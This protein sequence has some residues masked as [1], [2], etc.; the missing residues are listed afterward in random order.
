VATTKI[1]DKVTA[2]G[3]ASTLGAAIATSGEASGAGACG[4][5]SGIDVGA[6][7][8]MALAAMCAIRLDVGKRFHSSPES[9]QLSNHS[10]AKNFECSGEFISS[11]QN[12]TGLT[13][14]FQV[15][16]KVPIVR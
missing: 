3:A 16:G 9:A 4:G 10:E 15:V 2:I 13:G 11:L 14:Q 8:A 6:V 5:T 1:T 12:V 7:G